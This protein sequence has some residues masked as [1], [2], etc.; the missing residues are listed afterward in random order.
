MTKKREP[1]PAFAS[2]DEERRYWESSDSTPHVDWSQA[3]RVRLP[4]LKP[5]T[6]AISLRL[7]LALLDRIRI[8]ANERKRSQP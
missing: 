3:A 7:P 6:Q 1:I 8:A 5:S 2:E 4:N